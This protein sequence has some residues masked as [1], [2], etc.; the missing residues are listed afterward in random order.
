MENLGKEARDKVTKFQGII[1]SKITYLT[2]CDQYVVTPPVGADGKPGET[3]YFDV[4]RM[5]IVGE[6]VTAS[7]VQTEVKGGPNRDAPRQ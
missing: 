5:E 6:G 7:E 2:G 4:G 1:V 3:N